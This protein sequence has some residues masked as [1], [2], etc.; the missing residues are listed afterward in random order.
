MMRFT[1]LILI[2]STLP[3]SLPLQF[4]FMHQE[5]TT[6]KFPKEKMPLFLREFQCCDL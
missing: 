1:M 5:I 2:I 3:T 6:L 4:M